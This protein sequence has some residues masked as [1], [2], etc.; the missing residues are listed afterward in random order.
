MLTH[1]QI[2]KLEI[3]QH[4][5]KEIIDSE[6]FEEFDLYPDVTLADAHQAVQEILT[7]YYPP[8]YRPPKPTKY[9][10]KPRPWHEKVK[11][12]VFVTLGDISGALVVTAMLSA[13]TSL[14]CWGISDAKKAFGHEQ[15]PDFAAQSELYRGVA[16]ASIGLALGCGVVGSVLA[17]KGDN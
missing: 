5:L 8:G 13:C 14:V 9:L 2:E 10:Y 7:N 11:D 3:M 6:E 17:N 1:N 12:R 4:W 15:Q 16:I